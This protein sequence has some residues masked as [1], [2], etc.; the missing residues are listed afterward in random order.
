MFV[1][2]VV[3]VVVVLPIV[4]FLLLHRNDAVLVVVTAVVG[5]VLPSSRWACPRGGR[6]HTEEDRSGTRKPPSQWK[7]SDLD[8]TLSE[9]AETWDGCPSLLE[10]DSKESEFLNG[11]REAYSQHAAL[12]ID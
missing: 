10:G 4:T 2:I 9:P 8:I 11:V 1:V 5:V 7:V 6:G 3:V 12:V